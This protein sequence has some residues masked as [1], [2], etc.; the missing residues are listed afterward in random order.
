MAH[1]MAWVILCA[2]VLLLMVF[3]N[4]IQPR[5]DVLLRRAAAV[6]MVSMEF[7][8]YAW[9]LITRGFDTSLLPLGVCALSLYAT[10]F[11]LWFRSERVFRII[12]PWAVIG[13]LLSLS[14]ADVQ[15]TLPH[16]R[17]FHYFGNHSL[18]L[19]GNIYLIVHC[20][21][22]FKYR[23]LIRSAMVLALYALL[24]YPVNFLL[25]ANHL[26]LRALPAEVDS[27]F[28]FY[29]ALWPF[30]FAFLILVLFH[31]VYAPLHLRDILRRRKAF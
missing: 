11:A 27:L 26:F 24:V 18:F 25:Q 14:I 28:S 9:Y 7:G 22:S 29:G 31:I 19:L 10:S 3:R 17:Y 30:A 13:A 23:H 5:Q 4:Q 16:F 20:D 8:F 21:F 1:V 6:A 15:Y 2:A 12:F